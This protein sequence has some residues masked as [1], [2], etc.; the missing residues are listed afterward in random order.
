MMSIFIARHLISIIAQI[1]NDEG[2]G[3]GKKKKTALKVQFF[4]ALEKKEGPRG[5]SEKKLG[6]LATFWLGTHHL[7]MKQENKNSAAMKVKN[8][9]FFARDSSTVMHF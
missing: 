5:W 6:A 7:W 9:F 1:A 3:E 4:S 8:I 2:K